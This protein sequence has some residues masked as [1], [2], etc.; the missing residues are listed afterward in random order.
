MVRPRRSSSYSG[1]VSRASQSSCSLYNAFTIHPSLSTW[2]FSASD[3]GRWIVGAGA[4]AG[5]GSS[6]SI[7]AGPSSDD[8]DDDE[9]AGGGGGG[10]GAALQAQLA[11]YLADESALG[12][13]APAGA[14]ALSSADFAAAQAAQKPPELTEEE[15]R[16]KEEEERRAME[17]RLQSYQG[18]TAIGS[19]MLRGEADPNAPGRL[20]KVTGAAGDAASAA[21]GKLGGWVSS[22][23]SKAQQEQEQQQ[24]TQQ[25]WGAGVSNFAMRG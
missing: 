3:D 5:G 6:T 11:Q 9:P 22:A 8:D 7:G 21:I 24:A 18:A 14:T 4:G 2:A 10:G 25:G 1:F 13:A 17:A 15:I 19:N 12:R 16:A 20:A 23:L